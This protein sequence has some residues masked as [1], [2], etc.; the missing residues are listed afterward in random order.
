M[1]GR[2]DNTDYAEAHFIRGIARRL[3][4]KECCKDKTAQNSVDCEP[5]SW[6]YNMTSFYV[7]VKARALNGDGSGGTIKQN[8]MDCGE[9]CLIAA[10]LVDLPLLW[11]LEAVP[12]PG[13]QFVGWQ[14]ET[15]VPLEGKHKPL[16]AD[17][18]YAVF[19]PMPAPD[20]EPTP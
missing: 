5:A 2:Y 15:G 10:E 4:K 1:T 18:I 11:K 14:T 20:A 17:T 13:W 3:D 7:T 19:E 6:A 8:G 9:E 16:P 12:E